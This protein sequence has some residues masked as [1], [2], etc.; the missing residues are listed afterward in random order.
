MISDFEN[1]EEL[2][3]I[4]KRCYNGSFETDSKT[5]VKKLLYPQ[6]SAIDSIKNMIHPRQLRAFKYTEI[7]ESCEKAFGGRSSYI[8]Q[9]CNELMLCS[10]HLFEIDRKKWS[11]DRIDNEIKKIDDCLKKA[12]K[13]TKGNSYNQIYESFLNQK[14]ALEKLKSKL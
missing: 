4:G 1:I 8:A 3:F 5:T 11:R 14:S 2:N 7:K 9:E 10:Y 13:L 12:E 6:M